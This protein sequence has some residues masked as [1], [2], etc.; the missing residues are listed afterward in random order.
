M[1]TSTPLRA[2]PDRR[3][4]SRPPPDPLPAAAARNAAPGRGCRRRR[5]CRGG[6]ARR[7]TRGNLR[8]H[9]RH[10]SAQ[11]PRHGPTV[12]WDGSLS[13]LWREQ[14]TAVHG[15]SVEGPGLGSLLSACILV[16]GRPP[17]AL[18]EGSLHSHVRARRESLGIIVHRS[19]ATLC[20]QSCLRVT[21]RDFFVAVQVND[22]SRT[23]VP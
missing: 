21:I 22:F 19:R 4:P 3:R 13:T 20:R 17:I 5:R 14:V 7:G 6:S 15:L 9:A 16:A 8:P 23:H 12:R 10:L 2:L 18:Q 1:L 11:P